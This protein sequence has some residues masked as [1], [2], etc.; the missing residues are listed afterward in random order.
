[1]SRQVIDSSSVTDLE[2]FGC[3][4]EGGEGGGEGGREGSCC[5]ERTEP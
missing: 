5:D 4:D 2:D 3:A 1:M